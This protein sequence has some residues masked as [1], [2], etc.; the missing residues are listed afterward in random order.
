MII[1]SEDGDI[2]LDNG[3]MLMIA[4]IVGVVASVIGL[5]FCIAAI[6]SKKRGRYY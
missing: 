1:G 2:T 6:A 4:C 5:I 3:M